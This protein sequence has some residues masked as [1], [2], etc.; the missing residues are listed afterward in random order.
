MIL[1]A[2]GPFEG[3][4]L[5][6]IIDH[7]P[8]DFRRLPEATIVAFGLFVG[9][10]VLLANKT[11]V[12]PVVEMP[13]EIPPRIVEIVR[14]NKTPPSP[15]QTVVAVHK[16]IATPS[17]LIEPLPVPPQEIIE[18]TVPETGAVI[19]SPTVV[20]PDT[21]GRPTEE[22]P[23]APRVILNPRWAALPDARDLERAYPPRALENGVEG[24]ATLVC[25][26]TTQGT[27]SACDVATESPAGQGFGKAALKLAPNFRMIPKTEDGVPVEGGV[28]RVPIRF[29]L[30]G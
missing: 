21:V 11:F 2:D 7:K 23:V 30:E 9:L 8:K 29:T 16:P 1:R 14:L 28:V 19:L 20:G 13:P 6:H 27:L 25:L 12:S 15:T 22:V 4:S 5:A 18:G 3:H 17:T 10:G 24:S 26:V